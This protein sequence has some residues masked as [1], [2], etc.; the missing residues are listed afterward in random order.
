MMTTVAAPQPMRHRIET[1]PQHW[2]ELAAYLAAQGMKLDLE[3]QPQQFAGGFANLNYLIHIDGKPAVLR[4]PPRGPWPPGAYDMGREF[5][6]L[7]RLWEQFPLAPRGLH[8]CEDTRVIGVPF[9]IVEYRAGISVRESLPEPFCQDAVVAKNLGETLIDLLAQLHGVDPASVGLETLG[10]PAGFLKRA[11][12]G[13]IKRASLAIEGWGTERAQQLIIELAHW[14]RAHQTENRGAVLLH[15]DFKLDNVLLDPQ[16]LQPV[17]VLDWDQGTRGDGLYDLAILLSY[18]TERDDP[19]A[20]QQMAQMPTAQAGFPTREQAA[21]RYAQKVGRKLD[22][23]RFHRVL[24]Q[25]RTA[26]IFQQLHARYRSGETRD[27]RYGTFGELGEGLLAFA[28]DIA[29]ERVF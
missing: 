4:R 12:E 19:E 9:Q 14:L 25:V 18:W 21:Q 29:R 13:W 20:M 1:V 2:R 11:A 26:V 22:D 27:P 7:S 16:S 10:K 28:L 5:R 17:A 8:L 3:T 6:I 24:A 15:N 23:F